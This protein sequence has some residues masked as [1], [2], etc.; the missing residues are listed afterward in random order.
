MVLLLQAKK[1]QEKLAL[2]KNKARDDFAIKIRSEAQNL[3]AEKEQL[4]KQQAVTVSNLGTLRLVVGADE[5]ARAQV[6]EL[7]RYTR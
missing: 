4:T 6:A 5:T 3:K 7:T 2:A 1:D